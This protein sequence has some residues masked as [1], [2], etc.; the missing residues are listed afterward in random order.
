MS[1]YQR[2]AE[3]YDRLTFDVDYETIAARID[4][5]FQREEKKPALVLDLA[6]GTGSLTSLLAQKGYDMIGVDASDA[7]LQKAQEKCPSSLLLLQNMQEFELYG[8]VDAI[9][10]MLDSV[11]YLT[12]DGDLISTR[13]INSV[14]F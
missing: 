8:T 11:N 2:F 12:E 13:N 7:M 9:V 10:C 6:C 1:A 5:I 14:T 3:L 4:G